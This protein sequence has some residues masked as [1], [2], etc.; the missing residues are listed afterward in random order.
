M[1]PLEL[2][3]RVMMWFCGIPPDE[4]AAKWKRMAYTAFVSGIIMVHLASVI[5]S[6]EFIRRNV[7]VDL[8]ITLLALTCNI[9]SSTALYQ[10]VATVLL[11]HKMIEIFNSL[12]KI[13]EESKTTAIFLKFFDK[14]SFC[15]T[16]I[17]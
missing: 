14:I 1:R 16:Q 11:R 7:S 10:S 6:A 9:G 8:E 2:C 17:N 12:S 15:Q 5:S 4:D 13:F 3:Q